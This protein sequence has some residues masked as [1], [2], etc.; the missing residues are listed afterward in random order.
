MTRAEYLLAGKGKLTPENVRE[1]RLNRKGETRAVMAARYGVHINT[2]DK[3][4]KYESWALV[5]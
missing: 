1:I 2:I 5:Y 4:R 3:A